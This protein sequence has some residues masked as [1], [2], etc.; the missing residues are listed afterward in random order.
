VVQ[1][2][3]TLGKIA[4]RIGVSW[5]D[6]LAVNPQ[7]YN[8]SLIYTGQ[9]IN[10]PTGASHPGYPPPQNPRPRPC[11]YD[12]PPPSPGDGLSTLKIDYKHGMYIRSEP[13]GKVLA[14]ALHKS[15]VYYYS[16]SVFRIG[17]CVWV[18]VKVF[19]PTKGYYEGW[20]LVKDQLGKYFTS[21]QIG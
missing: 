21:P 16:N 20:L 10:L 18:K 11:S 14:S 2:G 6:I 9:V 7:I 1:Q 12:C 19:P 13:N 8:P 4:A 17:G 3:D 5:R 15:T